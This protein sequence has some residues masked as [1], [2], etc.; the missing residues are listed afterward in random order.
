MFYVAP[1]D[2]E[3]WIL[4]KVRGGNFDVIGWFST[5]KDAEF[6][7]TAFE[8]RDAA[9]PQSVDETMVIVPDHVTGSA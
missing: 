4:C 3:L 5:Q 9:H 1:D 8:T 2:N 6:A 7:K